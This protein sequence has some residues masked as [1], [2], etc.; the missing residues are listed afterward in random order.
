MLNDLSY[1]LV[2]LF[3]GIRFD[4][5]VSLSRNGIKIQSYI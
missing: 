2:N 3:K 1:F 4:K 5:F